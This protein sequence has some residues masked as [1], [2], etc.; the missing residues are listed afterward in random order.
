MGKHVAAGVLAIGL[1]GSAALGQAFGLAEMSEQS[2][3]CV[4]CHRS[5]NP[6][7][8]QQWGGSLHYRANIGCYECHLANEGDPDGFDHYG[9]RISVLV[10]PK[11]CARCHTRETA[12]FAASHHAKAGR[13][14]GSLDNV[15]AEVVEGSAGMVTPMF[16]H[17][18]SA[19]AV[20]GCWQCHGSEVKVNKDGKPDPATWPNSGIGR[21]NPDGSEGTCSSC[22][23][24]HVFS[25]AQARH[26][27]TCGKCHLGPDHPQKEIYEESKHGNMFFQDPDAANLKS[28]KW[29]VGQDYWTAPT[30]ATCHMSATS[31]Q[32]VTH[33]V[34]LR[35]SWNNRPEV[36]IRPEVA[37]AKMGLPSASVPWN[38][39][40]E[41]MK[42]VCMNCHSVLWIDGFYAQYDELI[43]LYNTKFGAPGKALYDLAKPLLQKEAFSN[44]LDWVWFELWHHEGRRARH[45]ASMMAPDYTHWHGMYDVAKNFYT[46]FIPQLQE[47]VEANLHDADPARVAAAQAL[48]TKINEALNSDA[49]KW[50]L[51]KIDPVE[52][53]RREQAAKDFKERY[54]K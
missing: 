41:N 12:E 45:G 49:H 3:M 47:L 42:E 44:E 27:D 24:R 7:L 14:L 18:V 46:E 10:T 50:F 32:P 33:D 39:R 36:S 38:V 31:K 30:C 26:P 51:G 35:I 19:S 17:G 1:A 15:L 2:R 28:P 52:A 54:G 48:Q 4:G 13:I 37:D 20:N 53:A 8:F 16:P 43:E 21:L 22:H 40:R 34:G 23:F 11:D 6:A 25:A 5:E 29:V 9:Q